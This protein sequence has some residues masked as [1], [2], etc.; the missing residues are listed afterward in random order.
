[1]RGME[2]I[3]PLSLQVGVYNCVCVCVCVGGGGGGAVAALYI[4]SSVNCSKK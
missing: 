3:C 2:G 4:I 1:M